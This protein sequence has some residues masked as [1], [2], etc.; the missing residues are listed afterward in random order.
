MCCK[1]IER[2]PFEE[3][4]GSSIGRNESHWG[5]WEVPEGDLGTLKG[6][7]RRDARAS[8]AGVSGAGIGCCCKHSSEYSHTDDTSAY[9]YRLEVNLRHRPPAHLLHK[10][11]RDRN[12]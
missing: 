2:M 3:D 1:G 9:T 4:P 10:L 8:R 7:D 5:D 12:I 6:R 11:S